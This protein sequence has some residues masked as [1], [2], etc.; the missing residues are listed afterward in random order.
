MFGTGICVVQAFTTE[1]IASRALDVVLDVARARWRVKGEPPF[2]FR[3]VVQV[4]AGIHALTNLKLGVSTSRVVYDFISPGILQLATPILGIPCDK[5][6]VIY[7]WTISPARSSVITIHSI[8]LLGYRSPR[9]CNLGSLQ[10][11]S[12]EPGNLKLSK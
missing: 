1:K 6:P 3:S 11:Y 7:P 9:I 12:Y 4:V 10:L 8:W 5:A 2:I